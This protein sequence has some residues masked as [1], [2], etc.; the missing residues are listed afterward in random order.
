MPPNTTIVSK[1]IGNNANNN[2]KKKS[3]SVHLI[4]GG[5]AGF[6]EALIC[7]PLD[8]IK[9]RMQLRAAAPGR[10]QLKKV[11]NSLAMCVSCQFANPARACL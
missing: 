4:A 8:T 7:H 1:P 3:L 2:N 11:S 10:S 5:A 9:V 6:S